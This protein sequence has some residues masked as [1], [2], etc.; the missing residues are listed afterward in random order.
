M[1]VRADLLLDIFPTVGN[2]HPKFRNRK[3]TTPIH[4]FKSAT[5]GCFGCFFFPKLDEENTDLLTWDFTQVFFWQVGTLLAPFFF[6]WPPCPATCCFWGSNLPSLH[7]CHSSQRR[8]SLLLPHLNCGF[9]K[10][11]TSLDEEKSH[12][13]HA[14]NC[15]PTFDSW[16]VGWKFAKRHLDCNE[17]NAGEYTLQRFLLSGPFLSPEK[18]NASQLFPGCEV[19]LYVVKGTRSLRQPKK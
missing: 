11:I 13:S 6:V 18:W 9:V 10:E 14:R 7:S 4:F 15:Q 5:L 8:P 2:I 16:S 1:P 19:D 12:R 3:P 17:K